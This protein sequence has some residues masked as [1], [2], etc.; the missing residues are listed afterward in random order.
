MVIGK[1]RAINSA[2]LFT[3]FVGLGEGVASAEPVKPGAV[4]QASLQV[5]CQAPTASHFQQIFSRL[6]GSENS[7]QYLRNLDKAGWRAEIKVGADMLFIER[8]MPHRAVGNTVVRYE[9]G[10]DRRPRWMAIASSTCRVKTVRRLDYDEYGVPSKLHYLDANFQEVGV[11]VDLNPPIPPHPQQ[12]GIA[13]A[14][15]DTGV[16]YLLPEIN[17]RL[18]RDTAGQVRGYDFW[19]LDQRPFDLNPIPSPFFPSHHGTKIASVII[20]QSPEATVMPYRFPRSEM[21]RMGDLIAHASEHGARIVNVSLAS[22]ELEAWQG[23]R[24]AAA[25]YSELL[26][27]VAAGNDA[28]DIDVSPIYPA[29]F[30]LENLVVVTASTNRGYLAP[31]ANWGVQSVDLIAPANKIQVM[32]FDGQRK[33]VGGSSYAA[34]RVSGLAACLLS[35]NP[36][37]GVSELRKRLFG[38]ARRVRG[39]RMVRYGFLPESQFN[40]EGACRSLRRPFMKADAKD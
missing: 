18:A 34:A 24:D 33:W 12:K 17:A 6:P 20:Q 36:E 10:P 31:Y 13:V 21:S 2:I 32:D 4:V 15:V 27:V 25:E 40:R 5:V 28:Q 9:E 29:A 11:T 22:S 26:F 39:G 23:F 1:R 19:D 37:M 16:N 35:Q 14:V 3:L 7:I 30:G 8:T 38:K